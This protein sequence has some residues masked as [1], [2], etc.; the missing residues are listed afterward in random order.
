MLRMKEHLL[1]KTERKQRSWKSNRKTM[2]QLAYNNKI[3]KD[4]KWN[5]KYLAFALTLARQMCWAACWE[6]VNNI[7][8]YIALYEYRRSVAAATST[9]R[10]RCALYEAVLVVNSPSSV[11]GIIS[12]WRMWLGLLLLLGHGRLY[13]WWYFQI[14]RFDAH[15]PAHRDDLLRLHWQIRSTFVN[16]TVHLAWLLLC[17]W[18]D[19]IF[20]FVFN[21]LYNM[22]V[23]AVAPIESIDQIII[24]AC[25]VHN[26]EHY[27]YKSGKCE[28]N[29]R[30]NNY[31]K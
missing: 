31:D 17:H 16:H 3:V 27:I 30:N 18:I 15:I 22:M 1:W 29:R 10:I 9:N 24:S 20:S 11:V 8:M 5:N 23:G 28:F 7:I 25:Q 14:A 19:S 6:T 4:K 12:I 13:P 21:K 2:T 26:T